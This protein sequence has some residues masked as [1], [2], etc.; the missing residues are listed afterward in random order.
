MQIQKEYPQLFTEVR[1]IGLVLGVEMTR[2]ATSMVSHCAKQGLLVGSAHENV[3]R[4]LPPLII[5]QQDIDQAL[6][7]LKKA[8]IDE[9]KSV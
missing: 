2:K 6:D 9:L 4:F 1:G 5:T 7:K 8:I 3:L